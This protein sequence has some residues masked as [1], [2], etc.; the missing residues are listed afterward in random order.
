MFV[1]LIVVA[2]AHALFVCQHSLGHFL[3]HVAVHLLGTGIFF[4]LSSKKLIIAE[5]LTPHKTK[6][7]NIFP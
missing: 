7:L 4:Q 1:F 3:F 6:S 2:N 5:T